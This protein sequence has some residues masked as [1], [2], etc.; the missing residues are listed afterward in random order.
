MSTTFRF[1]ERLQGRA[2]MR[3]ARMRVL[4]G[5][6][7]RTCECPGCFSPLRSG[8]GTASLAPLCGDPHSVK[9]VTFAV[10]PFIFY[11]LANIPQRGCFFHKNSSRCIKKAF[12]PPMRA[13]T[14]TWAGVWPTNSLR[15]SREGSRDSRRSRLMA[16]AWRPVSSR[17][18]MAS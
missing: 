7:L 15:T 5:K 18:P 12:A 8:Q 9:G 10:T 6:M 1:A 14:A 17:T 3:G 2:S 11:G 4:R 16:A 13:P